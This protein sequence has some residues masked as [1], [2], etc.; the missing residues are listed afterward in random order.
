MVGPDDLSS[1]SNLNDS[2]MEGNSRKSP[3]GGGICKEVPQL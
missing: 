2:A 1:L 3:I